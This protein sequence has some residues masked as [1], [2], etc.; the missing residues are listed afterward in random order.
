MPQGKGAETILQMSPEATLQLMVEPRLQYDNPLQSSM[1]LY[2]IY[3]GVKDKVKMLHFKKPSYNLQSKKGCKNWNPTINFDGSPDE[4]KVC[5]FELMG[6]M[7]PDEFDDGCARNMTGA[8]SN[9]INP[10]ATTE[11]RSLNDGIRGLLS[12]GI[13]DDFYRSG[14]FGDLNFDTSNYGWNSNLGKIEDPDKVKQMEDMLTNCNGWWSE[15]MARVHET[16]D[17]KINYVDTNNGTA[18][19]NALNPANIVPF[20][21]D[22][23]N[24]SSYVLKYWNKNRPRSEWPVFLLQEELY[25]AYITYLVSTGTEKACQLLIE[26][27]EMPYVYTFKGY[28]V[29]MM[30]EWSMF[31]AEICAIDEKKGIS[32]NQRAIFTASMNLCGAVDVDNI[33]NY[34]N[35]GLIVQTSEDVRDKGMTW[36]YMALRQGY[37]IA[38][39]M[40]MT[41]GY[42]SSTN[43]VGI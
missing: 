27:T 33:Q 35:T 1:G 31:D 23:Y 4:I 6:E 41:V 25:N 22:L 36:Y 21:Q 10:N 34:E 37:G 2:K 43:F 40:L 13:A 19:G 26:G 5:D 16:G 29:L 18:D 8:G 20:L 12:E 30:P 28:P 15:I 39:N 9:V 24:K 32:L 11:Q 17:G 42:N 3:T 38:H 14:W 7:C